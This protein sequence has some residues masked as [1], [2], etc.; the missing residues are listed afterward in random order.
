MNVEEEI[1]SMKA[2]M[3]VGT[4]EGLARALHMRRESVSMWRRRRRVSDSARHRAQM[5]ALHGALPTLD[6]MEGIAADVVALGHRLSSGRVDREKVAGI[7][8]ALA[9]RVRA[10]GAAS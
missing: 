8:D 5:I 2:Q 9:E 10:D 6:S 3:R 4:D 1:A 7:L